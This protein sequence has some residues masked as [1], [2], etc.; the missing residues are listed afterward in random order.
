[1]STI[2]INGQNF[3]SEDGWAIDQIQLSFASTEGGSGDFTVYAYDPDGP[4]A[5]DNSLG[6]TI[7]VWSDTSIVIEYD[8]AHYGGLW[9]ASIGASN[10]ALTSSISFEVDPQQFT[11][12]AAIPLVAPVQDQAPGIDPDTGADHFFLEVDGS[13]EFDPGTVTFA[14]FEVDGVGFVSVSDQAVDIS[15]GSMRI[16]NFVLESQVNGSPIYDDPWGSNPSVSTYNYTSGDELVGVYVRDA[17]AVDFVWV[18]EGI[19]MFPA[20]RMDAESVVSAMPG[21]LIFTG[22]NLTLVDRI[23]IAPLGPLGGS[24]VD[25][26]WNPDGP[27]AGSNA[28][29]L[30]GR[31]VTILDWDDEFI[32]LEFGAGPAIEVEGLVFQNS[33]YAK[34]ISMGVGPSEVDVTVASNE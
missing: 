27:N 13:E 25:I 8:K 32:R 31:G 24:Q 34:P 3:E 1:M 17:S 16:D 14:S 9:L 15:G 5:E 28:S 12:S 22:N 33:A 21:Q 23:R 11:G 20:P 26:A 6:L 4:N 18:G 7:D 10:V 19:E 2:T 30:S 29:V